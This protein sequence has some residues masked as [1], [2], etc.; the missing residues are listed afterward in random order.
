MKPTSNGFC[1]TSKVALADRSMRLLRYWQAYWWL[2]RGVHILPLKPRSKHLQPGYGP[3][4][5]HISDPALARQWF[6]NTD[7]NLGVLLGGAAGLA[8]ADWDDPHSYRLWR[9]SLGADVVTFIEQSPRGY[10]LF[11]F[12]SELPSASG[13]GCEFKS[14]GVCAVFPSIH[15]SGVLYRLTCP[16]PIAWLDPDSARQLF[17]FLSRAR[18]AKTSTALETSSR[19][20]AQGGLIER[21]KAARPI[22]DEIV[23]AGVALRPAGSN[24]LVGLCP[25]HDDH[26]PSLWLNPVSGLWGCNRP[27]CPAA[28]VHDVINFRALLRGISNRAAIK[29][30][31]DELL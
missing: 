11:F 10:H 28:G 9:T 13:D 18:T 29:L 8:V 21:I 23:A 24:T 1:S 22:Q 4:Q 12:G 19:L 30:L 7:A 17:P 15:P 14:R 2:A 31:A 25:F 6:L 3:R 16:A 27:D 5:A 26:S 20:L